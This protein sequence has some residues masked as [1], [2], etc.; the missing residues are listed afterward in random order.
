[1][2]DQPDRTRL[3]KVYTAKIVYCSRQN[4]G[5]AMHKKTEATAMRRMSV[6]VMMGIK[7]GTA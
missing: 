4:A 2:A 7:P 5:N 3:A 1:M 6:G